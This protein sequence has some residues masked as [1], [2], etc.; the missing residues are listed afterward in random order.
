MN[1]L[2]EGVVRSPRHTSFYLTCGPTDGTP[3][4]FLHGWPELSLSWR[5]QL[6]VF[7]SLGFRAIAPDMRGYGKSSVPADPSAYALE[8]IVD[9]VQDLMD[10]LGIRAAIF[11]GHDW[12]APV[13]WSMAQHHPER[14]LAVAAL[15]VPYIPEGFAPATLTPLSDRTIYPEHVHPAAQWDYQLFYAE[16]LEGATAAW[17][18]NVGATVRSMFRAGSPEDVLRPAFTA[19][20]RARGGFF[21]PGAGAPDVPRDEAVISAAEEWAYVEALTRNGF[22]G[23]DSWYV[24]AERNMDFAGRARERWRLEMPV[25]FLHAA[26]DPICETLK[27]RLAEPMR[28]WCHDLEEVVVASG[29]WM[30]QEK[31]T[32]VNAALCRWLGRKAAAQWRVRPARRA[33]GRAL[34]PPV[35]AAK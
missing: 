13:V 11:V 34:E 2:F 20:V 16:D 30:A 22:K 17:E 26:Y 15:C 9:D 6:P 24:N 29:H 19:G 18:K 35:G 32:E 21:G 31:P 7:G 8:E 12:G 28:H 23:P 25:L 4:I 10:H 27:S 33:T 1:P 14:C 5:G 3:I